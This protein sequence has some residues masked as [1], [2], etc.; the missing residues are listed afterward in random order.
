M[1]GREWLTIEDWLECGLPLC[2][3]AVRHEGRLERAEPS[4][5]R[6]CFSNSRLGGAALEDGS[7]QVHFKLRRLATARPNPRTPSSLSS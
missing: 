3:L 5:L 6:V 7:S 2:P 4:A 1:T